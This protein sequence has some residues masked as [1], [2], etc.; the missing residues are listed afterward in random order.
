M[1][2]ETILYWQFKNCIM[3]LGWAGSINSLASDPACLV[4]LDECSK[5]E[6]SKQEARSV[7]LALARTITFPL[8]KKQ[9]LIST[10]AEESTCVITR[11]FKTGDERVYEVPS[12][13]TGIMFEITIDLLKKPLDYQNSSGEYDWIK[14][15]KG[16]WLEDPTT[17][18]YGEG[19]RI[20]QEG[21]P[22]YEHQK[23][24]MVRK[25]KWRATNLNPTDTECHSY[26]VTSLYSLDVSWGDLL[27]KFIQALDDADKL[28]DLRNNFL[29]QSWKQIAASLRLEEIEKVVEDSPRYSLGFVPE[30]L[31]EDGMLLGGIDQ[32]MN[33]FYFIVVA[34]C[35]SGKSYVLDYGK[36]LTLDD[37]EKLGTKGYKSIDSKEEYFC[38]KFILD[39]GGFATTP[40]RDFSVKT[41]FTFTSC[42]GVAASYGS[43]YKNGQIEHPV[44]S[45][46]MIPYIT[47]NDD[48]MKK[49]LILGAIKSRNDDLYFPF[50][51][52][53]EFKK[54][55]CSEELI[56][57]KKD[58]WVWKPRGPNHFLDCLKMCWSLV[59]YN[60]R[61]LPIN[62]VEIEVG[63]KPT[64]T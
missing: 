43:A 29:G 24:E 57:N 50:N 61:R 37:V 3:K 36:L 53:D 27:V 6:D 28:K 26:V 25:G 30:Y 20:V 59:D 21:K 18:I 48:Q 13:T 14:I 34:L 49:Q 4:I 5:W 41:G 35:S 64:P 60:K 33:H 46:N 1:D 51:L 23:A 39:E 63:D 62:T 47:I 11:E 56:K 12:P 19:G 7:E 2:K 22:I 38:Q 40:I 32:Q 9:I 52:E 44:S 54:Q 8:E 55:L 58:E 15:K 42:K 17:R 16:V 45:G 10:P 31:G